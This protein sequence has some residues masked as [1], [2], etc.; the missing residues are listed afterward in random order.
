MPLVIGM[1]AD[2][3]PNSTGEMGEVCDPAGLFV[4]RW[5]SVRA[6]EEGDARKQVEQSHS[7]KSRLGCSNS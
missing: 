4:R 7:W 1:L 2:L 6:L 3:R 5:N